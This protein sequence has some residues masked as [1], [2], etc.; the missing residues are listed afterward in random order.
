MIFSALFSKE[1]STLRNIFIKGG[2]RDI[3]YLVRFTTTKTFNKEKY[4]KCFSTI[5]LFRKGIRA[6]KK[7]KENVVLFYQLEYDKAYNLK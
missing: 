1:L 3:F 7:E 4:F 6:R 2:I 5:L